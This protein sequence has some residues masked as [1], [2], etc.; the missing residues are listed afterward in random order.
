MG[1]NHVQSFSTGCQRLGDLVELEGV[2]GHEEQA[3]KQP[4]AVGS[5]AG[6]GSV[7]P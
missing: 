5:L 3:D 7:C 6:G 2:I 4:L 1:P